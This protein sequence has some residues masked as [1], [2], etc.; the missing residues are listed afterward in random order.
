MNKLERIQKAVAYLKGSQI[1]TKQQDIVDKMEVNKSSVS[2]ALKGNE[3]YLT[4]SFI[5]K[6]AETFN[7]N[8]DWLLK[9]EGFLLMDGDSYVSES[10]AEYKTTGGLQK[11]LDHCKQMNGQLKENNQTLKEMISILEDKIKDLENRNTNFQK[12]N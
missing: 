11:E 12:S 1:I 5:S 2:L 6:F 9:G 10:A 7:I 4:D 3:K 8:P